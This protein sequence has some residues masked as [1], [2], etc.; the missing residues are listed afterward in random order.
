[1]ADEWKLSIDNLKTSLK[2]ILLHYTNKDLYLPH[3]SIDSVRNLFFTN[4]RNKLL[5]LYKEMNEKVTIDEIQTI[6]KLFGMPKM[7]KRV[8]H[9]KSSGRWL[10]DC[11]EQLVE[12]D[13]QKKHSKK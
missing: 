3:F 4:R 6:Y 11:N 2:A 8:H 1:M 10:I 12:M 7:D 13:S 9:Y 5:C